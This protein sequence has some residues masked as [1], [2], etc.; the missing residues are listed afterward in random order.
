MLDII[1]MFQASTPFHQYF[2][3]G[4]KYSTSTI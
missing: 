1:I 2:S 3:T 4:T